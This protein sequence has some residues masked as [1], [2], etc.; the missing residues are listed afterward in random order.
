MFGHFFSS[1]RYFEVGSLAALIE[2]NIIYQQVKYYFLPN[3]RDIT[4]YQTKERM[5]EGNVLFN[6]ALHTLYLRLY[7]IRHMVKDHSDSERGNPL[8]PHGQLFLIS[9]KGSFI[10]YQY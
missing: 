3:S 6:N 8:L 4:N 1:T 2:Q 5:M 9:S 10:L 7:G